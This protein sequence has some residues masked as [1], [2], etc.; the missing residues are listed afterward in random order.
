ME[1]IAERIAEQSQEFDEISI[2]TRALISSI[3]SDVAQAQEQLIAWWASHG[4]QILVKTLTG[5]T[6][7]LHVAAND[8][9]NNVKAKIQVSEGI[10]P[11]VQRLLFENAELEDG[12]TLSDYNI[13]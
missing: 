8:T 5:K 12:Q 3:V 6:I 13:Q 4:M 9:I 11:D 2:T 1:S 7:T 10:P